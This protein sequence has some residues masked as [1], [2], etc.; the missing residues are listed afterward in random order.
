[1]RRSLAKWTLWGLIVLCVGLVGFF[2]DAW[3]GVVVALLLLVLVAFL[4]LRGFGPGAQEAN[5]M[6][7]LGRTAILLSLLGG[8]LAFGSALSALLEVGA[9]P[10]YSERLWAGWVALL[11]PVVAFLA[12]LWLHS[13]PLPASLLILVSGVT[14]VI[15]ISLFYLNTFYALALPFWIAAVV[16]GLVRPAQVEAR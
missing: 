7:P 5:R 13:R 1:M 2:V 16:V 10:I 8:V 15:C 6:R 4:V 3:I 12:T 14:G 9:D 11:L